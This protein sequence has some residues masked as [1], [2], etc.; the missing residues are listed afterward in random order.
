MD[1]NYDIVISGAG[2]VGTGLAAALRNTPF[3]IA[4]LETHLP[5]IAQTNPETRPLSLN[6]GSQKI[7]ETLGV[8]KDISAEAQPIARVHVSEQQRLGALNFRASEENVPALGWVIPADILQRQLYQHAAQMPSVKFISLQKLMEIQQHKTG[9][10]LK[11]QTMQG[12]KNLTSELL[13]IAEGSHST[14]RELLGITVKEENNDWWGLT[15]LIELSQE[16]QGVAYE[17]FTHQGPLAFLPLKNQRRGRVVWILPKNPAQSL[18]AE[19]D[20]QLA[21]L[22]QQAMHERLGNCRILERSR[23][24]P[25]QTLTA[26]EQIRRNIVLLGNAAHT[27]YPLAAQGFN[28]GLRDSAALA[29]VLVEARR[30]T[31]HLGDLAVLQSYLNWRISDQRWITRFTY[32]AGQLFDLHIP[33]LGALRGMGLLAAELTPFL[34]HRLAKRLMGISGRLPKLALGVVL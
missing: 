8:W 11:L 23:V 31:R 21:G 9:L 4:I 2:L 27:L 30:Q 16:H 20:V 24:F 17:R 14:S 29:E 3:R 22:L 13:V 10:S 28:L 25:L 6:Y 34:K 15:A 26:N 5:E 33:G 19:S 32:G 18:A 1:E 7:L 12:E